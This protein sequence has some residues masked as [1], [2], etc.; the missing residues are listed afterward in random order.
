MLLKN[1]WV[2]EEIKKETKKY[3]ETNDNEDTATPNL[4]DKAKALLRGNFI[5]IHTF[6]KK[7]EKSQIDNIIHHLKELLKEEETNPKANRRKEIIN[8]REKIN[9][10]EN[11]KTIE[12]NQ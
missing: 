3:L 6:L 7:D 9:K 1:Q 2:K 8:I 12:K 5:P 11:Q 10:I 4:Q